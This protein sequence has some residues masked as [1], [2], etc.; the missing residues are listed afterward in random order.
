ME[1]GT[2]ASEPAAPEAK[3]IRSTTD[4]QAHTFGMLCH[5]SA[6]VALVGIPFGNII[7]PLIVWLL[8]KDDH[9]FIDDQGKESLNFQITVTLAMIA[10]G[11]LCCI[12]I[13]LPLLFL[14]IV[15]GLILTIVGAVKAS[16]GERY[17]YPFT[18]RLLR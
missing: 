17:R 10:S 1:N 3:V 9:E 12:L 7:G 11:I 8:K 18:I 14:T 6:L 13:G 2:P 15:A 16:A 4:S 5:L